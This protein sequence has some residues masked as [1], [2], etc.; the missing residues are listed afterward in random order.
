MNGVDLKCRAAHPYQNDRQVT[1]FPPPPPPAIALTLIS[2][3]FYVCEGWSL[4]AELERRIQSLQRGL[5]T[6]HQRPCDQ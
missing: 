4:T 3:L 1:P 5:L 6:F 2:T